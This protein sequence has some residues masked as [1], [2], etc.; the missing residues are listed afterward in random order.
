MVQVASHRTLR[1]IWVRTEKSRGAGRIMMSAS[2][3]ADD[4]WRNC[5]GAGRQDAVNLSCFW[6]E[7]SRFLR[8][9]LLQRF[10]SYTLRPGPGQDGTSRSGSLHGVETIPH[11]RN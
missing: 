4:G 9:V 6:A 11:Q 8:M 1:S 2:R 3:S 5:N 7:I 10:R